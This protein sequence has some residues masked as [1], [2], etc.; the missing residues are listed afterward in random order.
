LRGCGSRTRRTAMPARPAR[1]LWCGRAR[2][3][4]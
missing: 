4:C 2:P 3:G 1:W